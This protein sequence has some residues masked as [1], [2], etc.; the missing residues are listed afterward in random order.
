MTTPK[1][2]VES[3]G[4]IFNAADRPPEERIAFFT[5]LC[6]LQSG[7]IIAGHQLGPAKQSPTGTIRLHRSLDQGRTWSEIPFRFETRIDG[8]PGSLGTAEI[9]EAEPGRLLLFCT[10]FDRSEP[11]RPLFDPV[12][13]GILRSKQ[14][15]TF[16]SDEGETWSDWTIIPT[17][18]LTGTAATG[19]AVRWSNGLIAFPFESFK[20][21]DDPTP[22]RHA[23]WVV[24]T[25]DAG[26]TFS[27][28]VLLARHPEH[29]LYYWD[30]RLAPTDVPGEFIALFWT[31]DLLDRKDL[32]VHFRHARIEHSHDRE[33]NDKIV[34]E[35]IH[36]TSIP[37]QIAAPVWIADGRIFAFVVDRARPGTMT[38][39][40][41]FDGGETW[42]AEQRLV[43]HE[44]DEQARL[45]QG[46]ENIDFKQY[47]EDMGKWSFGHPAARLLPDGKLLLAYY[48]G[49]PDHM[50][51]HW[52]RV[53]V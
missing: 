16:S 13:E 29:R 26:R 6:P 12:T 38:L 4:I 14:I 36:S 34:G 1:P 43:V 23:A 8:I 47:W 45:S 3:R 51:I 9:V 32:T 5:T 52:V 20:E 49:T 31:H 48:A 28:P 44:H 50:S 40:T 24:L 17:P 2:S 41:S 33:E 22:A 27:P 21:F 42:P 35:P 10:W 7:A 18:G 37:G 39:W 11:G 53:T 25:R 19:P 46:L 15:V 30:Q